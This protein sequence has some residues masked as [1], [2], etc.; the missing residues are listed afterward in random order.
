M[1]G[2]RCS[3]TGARCRARP[4]ARAADDLSAEGSG[5]RARQTKGGPACARNSHSERR[6]PTPIPTPTQAVNHWC[7]IKGRE[8][9]L[10]DGLGLTVEGVGGE[11]TLLPPKREHHLPAPPGE[12]GEGAGIEG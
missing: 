9:R 12:G 6:I 2:R 1:T 5:W 4:R 7:C 10:V 11:E 3:G 8:I